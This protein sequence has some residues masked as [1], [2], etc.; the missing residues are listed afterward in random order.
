MLASLPVLISRLRLKQLRLLIALDE[1]GTLHKAAEQIAISQ[2]GATKALNDMEQALGARLFERTSQG[3]QAS[4]LGG[5]AIRYARLILSDLE[6]MHEE[7]HAILQGQGGRLTVGCIMGALPLLM[8]SLSRL[9]QAQPQLTVELI[10]DRSDRLLEL[11][12]QGRLDLAICRTSVSARPQAYDCLPLYQERVCV[13]AAPGHP[14]AAAHGPLPLSRLAEF[15]WVVFPANMPMRRVLEREFSDHG[16]A[17]PR[18]A[19]ETASTFAT[20]MLLQDDPERVALMPEEVAQQA[21]AFAMLVRLPCAWQAPS[22]AYA[23]VSRHGSSLSSAAGLLLAQLRQEARV[24][25]FT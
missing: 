23:V 2:P 21:E 17:F 11:L 19:L 7:M 3:L 25:G 18:F 14:L 8:R 9:R 10:E 24:E 16:L 5:C 4:E 6:H 20:L 1:Q 15:P 22:E 13:V 12:D